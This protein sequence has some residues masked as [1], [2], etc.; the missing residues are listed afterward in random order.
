MNS[1]LPNLLKVRPVLK[2]YLQTETDGETIDLTDRVLRLTV[3]PATIYIQ[4]NLVVTNTIWLAVKWPIAV[5][6]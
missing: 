3:A 5:F 4:K 1:A 2:C 6:T